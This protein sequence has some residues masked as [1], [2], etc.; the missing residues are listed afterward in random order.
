MMR[1]P[2]LRESVRQWELALDVGNTTIYA[3]ADLG[4]F[5]MFGPTGGPTKR[6]PTKRTVLP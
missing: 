4:M 5:S 2:S 1:R 6:G 3:V